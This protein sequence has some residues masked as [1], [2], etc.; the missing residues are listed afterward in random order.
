ME[1]VEDAGGADE[2]FHSCDEGAD[3]GVLVVECPRSQLCPPQKPDRGI[4]RRWSGK[5][6]FEIRFAFATS[7]CTGVWVDCG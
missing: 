6:L 5:L 7:V 1:D 4:W 2:F 3:G